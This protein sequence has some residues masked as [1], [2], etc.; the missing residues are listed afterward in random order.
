MLTTFELVF[1]EEHMGSADTAGCQPTKTHQVII[2]YLALLPLL[3]K[4][5]TH[6][7]LSRLSEGKCLYKSVVRFWSCNLLTGKLEETGV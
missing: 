4:I 6:I 7:L 1:E 3:F 2:L 5:S